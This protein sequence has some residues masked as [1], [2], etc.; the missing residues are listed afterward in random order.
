MKILLTGR[1]GQVG[2]ELQA[3]LHPAVAT[4][5]ATLDLGSADAIRQAV[6]AAKPDV[7]INA[8][9]Y[10]AVDKAE[11]EPELAMRING[12]APGV[13]GEEAKQAGALLVHYSTDYVFDGTKR[14]PYL[15]T[16][17]P[18]PLSV[19]GRTKLEGE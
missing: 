3:I 2:S 5:H 13:L 10:T 4:D 7:I 1:T 18:K 15:E 16:D 11:G 17:P 8:A 6:R 19:Y 12:A 14:S 9:A